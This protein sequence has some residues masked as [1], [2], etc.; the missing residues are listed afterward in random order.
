M[1]ILLLIVLCLLLGGCGGPYTESPATTVPAVTTP[2]IREYGGQRMA[3]DVLTAETVTTFLPM[4]GG[5]LLLTG[6]GEL[7]FLEED[8]SLSAVTQ[9]DG[10]ILGLWDTAAGIA[11]YDGTRQQIFYL[12]RG[13]TEIRR[14]TL[15]QNIPTPPVVSSDGTSIYY[16]IPG[17]LYRWDLSTGIRQ[18]LKELNTEG[19][20][21]V[22]LHREDTLLQCRQAGQDLFFQT[23]DGHLVASHSGDVTLMT[24]GEEFYAVY[25]SGLWNAMVYGNVS[26]E[27]WGLYPEELSA[28]GYFL[29]DSGVVITQSGQQLKAYDLESGQMRDRLTLE[30]G[31][32]LHSLHSAADGRVL[33]L[34]DSGRETLCLYWQPKTAGGGDCYTEAYFPDESADPAALELCQTYAEEIQ[35]RYGISVCIGR[36]AAACAPWDY[37]FEAEGQTP[38]I[39]RMLTNLND[40]LSR[41]PETV[42]RET[43]AQFESLTICLVRSIAGTAE[44]GGLNQATGVQYL[45]GK[46]AYLAIAAGDYAAQSLCHELFHGMETRILSTSNALDDWDK[47]NPAGF[48]YALRYDS[49]ADR[50]VYLSGVHRAF[51]DQYSMSYPKEDRARIFEYAMLPDQA[52]TFRSETMQEKLQAICTGIREAYDLKGD[53]GDLPWEQYLD[54]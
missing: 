45:Q 50:G 7:S 8:M 30:E 6:T 4:E 5:Y 31:H 53:E 9:L 46:D 29:P 41:F 17:A 36:E 48:S 12:D 22:A 32:K 52:E 49:T 11:C 33:L 51:I 43:A 35:T 19:L 42:I 34:V 44:G 15:P 13:L 38:V 10:E 20:T 24:R 23:E 40:C 18:R 37:R 1:P 3:G 14:V 47:H 27:S 21:L 2:A 39:L 25:P 54:S 16:T 26:G 28:D